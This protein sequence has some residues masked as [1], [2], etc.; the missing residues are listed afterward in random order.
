MMSVHRGRPESRLETVRTGFD[1]KRTLLVAACIQSDGAE[2]QRLSV[3][4]PFGDLGGA[5]DDGF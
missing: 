1:P 4:R 5:A 3:G 2:F